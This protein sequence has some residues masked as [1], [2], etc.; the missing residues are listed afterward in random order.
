MANQDAVPGAIRQRALAVRGPLTYD[1]FM[2]APILL[3]LA[4]IPLPG[5]FLSR[6][7]INEPIYASQVAALVPGQTTAQQAVQVM[8]APADV[9]Q[10]GRRT[11]WRFEHTIEKQAG[12]ALIVFNMRGVDTHADRVWLFFDENSVLSHVGATLAGEQAAY[13][14]PW[15]SPHAGAE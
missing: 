14:L 15:S 4:L 13:A 6:S 8:G 7:T 12:L 3:L 5:C 9:V 2:R 10:L 11:A 1:L